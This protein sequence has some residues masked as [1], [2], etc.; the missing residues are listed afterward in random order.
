MTSLV[1][2]SWNLARRRLRAASSAGMVGTHALANG[3]SG[4]PGDGPV[5]RLQ[6]PIARP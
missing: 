1:L 6:R 3:W 4:D 5:A 2:V